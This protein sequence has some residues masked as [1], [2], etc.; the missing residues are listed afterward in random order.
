M[1][2]PPEKFQSSG[3][4]TC[5]HLQY[6]SCQGSRDCSRCVIEMIASYG[7]PVGAE[8]FE[9]CVYIGRLMEAFGPDRCDRLTRIE[10]KS[11]VCHSARAKD[12]NIRQAL[13]DRL[14]PP[15]TKR[16]PGGTYGISGDVWAALAVAVTWLDR[17][18]AAAAVSTTVPINGSRLCGR[19]L[20]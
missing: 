8:V 12:G 18:G 1:R 11:H 5:S 10:V 4:P 3:L 6:S 13:I 19:L 7:M 16:A 9:T 14:G 2:V 15:G 20:A 17:A